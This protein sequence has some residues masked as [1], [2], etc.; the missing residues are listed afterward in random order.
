MGGKEALR[1]VFA[2]L[3]HGDWQGEVEIHH[4]LLD[5]IHTDIGHLLANDGLSADEGKELQRL[6]SQADFITGSIDTVRLAVKLTF[7]STSGEEC[8]WGVPMNLETAIDVLAGLFVEAQLTPAS[9]T[10]ETTCRLYVPDRTRDPI[11]IDV[12][13]PEDEVKTFRQ[14][15]EQSLAPFDD[16]KWRSW[17]WPDLVPL[18]HLKDKFIAVRLLPAIVMKFARKVLGQWPVSSPATEWW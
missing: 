4:A 17:D 12:L 10:N 5:C 18:W 3:L 16:C 13:L 11:C 1:R 7:A 14:S 6:R 9:G 8:A 2:E 15:W